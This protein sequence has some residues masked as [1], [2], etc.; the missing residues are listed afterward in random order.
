MSG[1]LIQVVSA[2][3]TTLAARVA[4]GA[5]SAGECS[6][7]NRRDAVRPSGPSS[8]SARA[9]R[10]LPAGVSMDTVSDQGRSR[11]RSLPRPFARIVSRSEGSAS[12]SEGISSST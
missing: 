5:V 6:T 2:S 4:S 1:T 8:Y 7:S 3:T 11:N 9:P 10:R 12:S